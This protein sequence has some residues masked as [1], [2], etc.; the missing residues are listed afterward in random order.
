[1]DSHHHQA[2]GRQPS[3]ADEQRRR[4]LIENKIPTTPTHPQQ[5]DS[6]QRPKTSG[7]LRVCLLLDR[8]VPLLVDAELVRRQLGREALSL[9]ADLKRVLEFL[10][11]AIKRNQAYRAASK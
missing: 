3:R 4:P 2:T 9:L 8:E 10:L 11:N 5:R 1:M 7:A 6:H